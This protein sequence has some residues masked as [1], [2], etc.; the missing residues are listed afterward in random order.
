MEAN[1]E[2]TSLSFVDRALNMR[3]MANIESSD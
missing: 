1:Q 2:D 3:K